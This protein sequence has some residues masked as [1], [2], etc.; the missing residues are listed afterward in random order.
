MTE[1][2]GIALVRTGL[3]DMETFAELRSIRGSLTIRDNFALVG[4]DGL[5]GLSE[6]AGE[7]AIQGNRSLVDLNGLN[8]I[9]SLQGDCSISENESLEN[10]D[11][12]GA[13]ADIA[14]SLT[15]GD[16]AALRSIGMSALTRLVVDHYGDNGSV[17]IFDNGSLLD[18]DG[19]AALETVGGSLVLERNR[20]LRS[21]S[22][23]HGVTSVARD[24]LTP[25]LA[26][27]E[28]RDH[29]AL[30]TCAAMALLGIWQDAG[31]A[32]E[33]SISGNDDTATCE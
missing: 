12:L 3:V 14:G 10:I 16:N 4:V 24:V 26:R 5:G 6:I 1:V 7:L 31:F 27:F 9:S 33:W 18:L 22:G 28:V 25:E 15:I 21:V 30:P 17:A 8:G 19:L 23:L 2:G 13:V 32:N 29:E 20:Q 11:G